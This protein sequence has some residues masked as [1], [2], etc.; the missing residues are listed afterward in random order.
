[1]VKQCFRN[2]IP[3][4]RH[5]ESLNF[6]FFYVTFEPLVHGLEYT[7][8]FSEK[9]NTIE[10][11]DLKTSCAVINIMWI[12]SLFTSQLISVTRL[13]FLFGVTL[14]NFSLIW[15]TQI[16]RFTI[17]KHFLCMCLPYPSLPIELFVLLFPNNILSHFI[18][19]SF[20]SVPVKKSS[21]SHLLKTFPLLYYSK[22]FGHLLVNH[23]H[24]TVL[25]TCFNS[26]NFPQM[27]FSLFLI[28]SIQPQSKFRSMLH[29]AAYQNQ[30]FYD[31]LKHSRQLKEVWGKIYNST[32][33]EK[34]PFI[35]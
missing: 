22:M 11:F 21:L 34:W 20:M 9:Q 2:V 23:S 28:R 10:S 8:Q 27:M 1:M 24:I 3:R 5:A 35:S 15:W 29:G 31:R 30:R 18:F 12:T 16:F 26:Q 4:K 17:V 6:V 7:V 32:N 25:S 14:K 13:S 19:K 33:F